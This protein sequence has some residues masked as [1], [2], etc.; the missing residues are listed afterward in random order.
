[1]N[2]D[3][4]SFMEE[5]QQLKQE[6]ERIQTRNRRVDAD[7][8]W[9]TSLSRRVLV[10]FLTYCVVALFFLMAEMSRPFVGAVVPTIGFIVS[11]LTISQ[12]K[13]YWV[14]KNSQ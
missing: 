5:L 3:N 2:H 9:E 7:K 11:T 12:F 4:T 10:A 1:M 6:I 8:A 14:Q 13:S